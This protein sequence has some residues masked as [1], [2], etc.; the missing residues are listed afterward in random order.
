MLLSLVGLNHNTAPLEIRECLASGM[1]DLDEALALLYENVGGGVILSTCNRTE[2]YT[3]GDD[4]GIVQQMTTGL[5]HGLSG[6]PPEKLTPYLYSCTQDEAVEHLFKVAS[7][8]DSLIV[9]EYEILG[10][11]RQALEEAEKARMAPVSVLNLFRQAV[12]VGRRVRE[13]THISRNAASVSS[14][15]VEMAKRALGDLSSA[16]VLVIG[17]GE[18]GRLATQALV[19]HGVSHQPGT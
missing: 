6:L 3:A 19:G 8:L 13:E 4:A 5:M 11:V 1:A 15:A 12:S 16:Q 9:G 17:A 14:V 10:Q 18:A 2:I 7:G